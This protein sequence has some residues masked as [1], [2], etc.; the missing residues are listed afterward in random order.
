MTITAAIMYED[1]AYIGSDSLVVC[2]SKKL[3][4]LKN[5]SKIIKFDNFLVGYAG[6]ASI[7]MAV[8]EV[9][10][11]PEYKRKSFLKMRSENDATK[12]ATAVAD[13]LDM[14]LENNPIFKKDQDMETGQLII[15]SKSGIYHIDE[16][17]GV[18][19]HNNFCAIGSGQDFSFGAYEVLKKYL[20][21]DNVEETLKEC[22]NVSCIHS[23]LCEG[24]IVM[25]SL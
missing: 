24:P 17:S 12:F 25:E 22:I 7:R 20:N 16:L 3:T 2:G 1:V 19:A 14:I 21:K 13:K 5:H 8:L 18:V 4:D 23:N 10:N 15:L 6:L 9:K 11:S